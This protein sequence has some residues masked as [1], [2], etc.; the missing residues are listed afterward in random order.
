MKMSLR[1]PALVVVIALTGR[2]G[3]SSARA[4]GKGG[5]RDGDRENE[6]CEFHDCPFG[7][8]ELT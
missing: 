6:G 8:T 3:Q 4:D 5:R 7:L 2:V 1:P